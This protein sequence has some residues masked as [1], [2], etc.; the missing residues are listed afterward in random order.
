M[1]K[2]QTGKTKAKTKS[3]TKR[4][5]KQ[6]GVARPTKGKAAAGRAVGE[7]SEAVSPK[8]D[9]PTAAEELKPQ[10]NEGCAAEE[11]KSQ[12]EGD[13]TGD[14]VKKA[15]GSFTAAAK[16]RLIRV[17]IEKARA[18]IEAEDSKASM[19]DLI[20]LLQLEQELTPPKA[21]PRPKRID[22]YFVKPGEKSK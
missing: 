7:A 9:Q 10:A 16:R 11:S 6:A 3:G 12:P 19:G 5:A 17:L 8:V 22:V 21:K 14:K 4:A 2:K 15:L 20:R 1:A 18:K 13:T